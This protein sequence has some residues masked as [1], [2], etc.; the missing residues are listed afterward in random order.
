MAAPTI[1]IG[2]DTMVTGRFAPSPSGRMHLGNLFSFLL[3]WCSVRSAGGEMVLRMEDLDPQRTSAEYAA[4]IRR[5][6]L[7][8]GLDWDREVPCQ[9]T[10]T[11]AYDAAFSKLEEMGLIY[12]C[13]CSRSQVHAASAPHLGQS[14]FVYAGTCRDL[15][16]AQRAAKKRL[17]AWRLR[18]PNQEWTVHDGLQGDYTEL[19]SRDCGDFV[20]RRA[21]G[22]YAYQLAVVVDD[23]DNGITQVVR[24]R[25]LLA[26]AP[27][28]MYLFSLLGRP[29]PEYLHVPLL[30]A[31]DGRRLS[32]RDGDLDLEALLGRFTPEEILGKLAFSAGLL[33]R[34]EAVSAKELAAIFDWRRVRKEDICLSL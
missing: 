9:S 31:P 4:L 18:V 7:R 8:F 23:A 14:E 17:P 15:T 29:A 12:P 16:P 33:D 22:V 24:G 20:V 28:Q 32:K 10:R 5:D 11:A 3:A 27:R 30:L 34:D 13:Y 21:D 1:L 25:D 26:S 19:L 6:L 2:G